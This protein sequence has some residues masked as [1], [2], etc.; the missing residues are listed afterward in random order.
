MRGGAFG[1]T[2]IGVVVL[3]ACTSNTA[4]GNDRRAE[5]DPP[6]RGAEVVEAEAAL[7]GVDH[8]L[9]K[10]AVMTDA[11]LANLPAMP[12]SCRFHFTEVGLPAVVYGTEAFVKLNG[13]LI[14]LPAAGQGRWA[15]AG[16]EITIAPLDDGADRTARHD[17]EL[18]MRAT[19]MS[20]ELGF[21]GV[22]EC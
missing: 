9:L 19:G 15:A 14:A 21:H 11:D 10:P 5:L 18:V 3:A 17:A 16:V 8:G 6:A 1:T 13:K 22:A 2:A 20:P 7:A 12:S 4:P